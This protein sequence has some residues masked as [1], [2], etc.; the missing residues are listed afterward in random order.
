MKTQDSFLK[1]LRVFSLKHI[2]ILM[3]MVGT[4][5][6]FSQTIVTSQGT[7]VL[8][9][10]KDLVSSSAARSAKA[11]AELAIPAVANDANKVIADKKDLQNKIDAYNNDNKKYDEALANYN[12]E[13]AVYNSHLKPYEDELA[14]YN[15]DLEP[16]NTAVAANNALAP[17]NRNPTTYQQL[18]ASKN[19]LD[20]WLANLNT[21][22]AV[23]DGELS[24]LNTKKAVLDRTLSDLNSKFSQYDNQY[25]SMDIKLGEAYRQLNQLH[26]YAIEINKLLEKWQEP[27]INTKNLNTPLE[28]LKALSNKGWD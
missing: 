13:L 25:K 11:V 21:K 1:P 22:K 9:P 2:V 24:V 28:Q 15:R 7:F 3:L 5:P 10:P 18:V 4:L 16:H 14:L 23:L 26:Q 20:T 6:L 19:R 17:E 27:I 12:K 8:I